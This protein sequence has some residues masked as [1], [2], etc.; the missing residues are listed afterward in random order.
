MILDNNETPLLYIRKHWILIIVHIIPL[1]FLA[2]L[3]V[4]FPAILDTF[5]PQHLERFEDAAWAVYCMW[6]IVLWVWGF[7]VWTEHHLDVWV[8]TKT[9]IISADQKSLFNR[10][11]STVELDK[12]QD[13]TVEVDGFIQ[14]MFSYGTLRLQTAG[15]VRKFSLEGTHRP[16]EAKEAILAAQADL[17]ENIL[18]RQSG[19]IR[20]GIERSQLE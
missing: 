16:E 7:L 6:L 5:L 18:K 4:I 13:I 20:E 17:R 2:L 8:L 3:P 9:K 1:L 12:I 10:H 11:M 15:E 14:T 19:Y